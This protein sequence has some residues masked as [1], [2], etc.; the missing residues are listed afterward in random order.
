MK[1]LLE[2]MNLLNRLK[3][4]SCHLHF[5]KNVSPF[6]KVNETLHKLREDTS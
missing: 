4:W 1:D 3:R 6:A 2:V 5:M